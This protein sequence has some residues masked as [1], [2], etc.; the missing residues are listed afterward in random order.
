MKRIL[1]IILT[2]FAVMT[3]ADVMGLG[4]PTV[5]TSQGQV[6]S[7]SHT[8][9]LR[10]KRLFSNSWCIMNYRTANYANE[11]FFFGDS[12]LSGNFMQP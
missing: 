3:A 1:T 11:E 9:W 10:N 12:T 5:Q 8:S 7:E 6:L 2:V 4:M